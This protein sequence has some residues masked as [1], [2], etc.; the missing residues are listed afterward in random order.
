M[1]SIKVWFHAQAECG[2]TC[3]LD[4]KPQK[5]VQCATRRRI[6]FI[7]YSWLTNDGLVLHMLGTTPGTT[8]TNTMFSFGCLCHIY[9]YIKADLIMFKLFLRRRFDEQSIRRVT[10]VLLKITRILI[11][12]EF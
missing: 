1:C 11:L 12:K 5:S 7:M 3:L 6:A 4:E 9:G 10:F 8:L 2:E